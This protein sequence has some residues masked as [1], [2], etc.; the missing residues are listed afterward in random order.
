LSTV[1]I[2]IICFVTFACLFMS[3]YCFCPSFF[4][5]C[6]CTERINQIIRRT[7][8]IPD[9][10]TYTVSD[11]PLEDALNAEGSY[12]FTEPKNDNEPSIRSYVRP[13]TQE[14]I[15]ERQNEIKQ[16]TPSTS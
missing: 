5:S 1:A 2:V 3:I 4:I 11:T 10:Q 9:R 16:T 13:K 14:S 6:L 8:S 12:W 15:I 7:D